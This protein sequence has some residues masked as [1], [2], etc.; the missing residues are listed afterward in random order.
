MSLITRLAATWSE[1][2]H[3]EETIAALTPAEL[4]KIGLTRDQLAAIV[5]MPDEQLG[6]L[7]QMA[8]L[9]GL[10]EGALDSAPA[11]RREVTR[12]CAQRNENSLCRQEMTHGTT[13]ARAEMFCANAHT[14]TATT[15][16]PESSREL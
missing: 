9:F 6:R 11:L 5:R 7:A 8:D 10:P 15:P 4:D 2:R 13:I 12:T 14:C 16:S 1:D 3:R